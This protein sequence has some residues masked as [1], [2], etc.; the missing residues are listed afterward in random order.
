M[1]TA[2]FIRH[3]ESEANAGLATTHP[4]CVKLTN[5]G[6]KQA[7]HI[8]DAFKKQPDTIITSPFIRTQQTAN[9]TMSR[10]PQSRH[11]VWQ[12]QEFTYHS[13]SGYQNTTI[14]QR[15]PIAEAYWQRED[16]FYVDGKGAESFSQFMGRVQKNLSKLIALNNDFTAIFSHEQFIRAILWTVYI[17]NETAAKYSESSEGM[18]QFHR[19][20][21][22][23]S[24]PNG[25]IVQLTWEMGKPLVASNIM[26]DHLPERHQ[27][28]PEAFSWFQHI[29]AT[30]K[31]PLP[32]YVSV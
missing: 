2:W 7:E 19:F 21:K 15:R 12:I 6:Y 25:S 32:A 17:G 23:F 24:M 30:L 31:P 1:P 16:P 5:Q 4:T 8:A 29:I 22:A 11:S 10:F 18:A 14:E 27:E 20:L 26:T 9:P 3:A 13:L 28:V